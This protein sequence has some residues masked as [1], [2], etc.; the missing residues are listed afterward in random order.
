MNNGQSA[1]MT[2]CLIVGGGVIGLS[3]A[4]E[5]A[6]HGMRV[7]MIDAAQPGREASWAGAGILPPASAAADQPLEQLA[8]L[9]NELHAQWSQEL[10]AST[11]I[12]N[13]YRR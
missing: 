13:G 8:A 12:D 11:Q 3:L 1:K 10:R 6:G 7:R 5:L 9:S 4:Y 2:D